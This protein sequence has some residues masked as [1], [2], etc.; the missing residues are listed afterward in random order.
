MI[1]QQ[2]EED[3]IYNRKSSNALRLEVLPLEDESSK[4]HEWVPPSKIKQQQ[5]QTNP[6]NGEEPFGGMVGLKNR[7]TEKG[8]G[9]VDESDSRDRDAGTRL[10]SYLIRPSPLTLQ[11]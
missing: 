4:K 5:M 10:I 6:H 9:L 1:K 2:E 3:E 7:K 8:K 11:F